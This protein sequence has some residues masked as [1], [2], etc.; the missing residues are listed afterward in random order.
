[1]AKKKKAAA[2]EWLVFDVRGDET[3]DYNLAIA[4]LRTLVPAVAAYRDR[5]GRMVAD[6]TK[7]EQPAS[8]D[9]FCY[10]LEY[11]DIDYAEDPDFDVQTDKDFIAMA[12]KPPFAQERTDIDSIVLTAGGFYFTAA[13]KH[14][15]TGTRLETRRMTWKDWDDWLAGKKVE[16]IKGPNPRKPAA[17]LR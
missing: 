14:D 16:A 17:S 9:W 3:A 13:P 5:Y 8:A 12:S 2:A 15:D 4:E 11:G 7:E 10:E 6:L 1:M